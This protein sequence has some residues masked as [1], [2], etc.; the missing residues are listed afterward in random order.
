MMACLD[1]EG[2]L[3]FKARAEI[4]S[5]L[6]SSVGPSLGTGGCTLSYAHHMFF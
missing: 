3:T 1:Q 4:V 6:L 2:L 5:E